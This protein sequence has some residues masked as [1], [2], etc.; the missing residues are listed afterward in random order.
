[1][2]SAV[3]AMSGWKRGYPQVLLR[4]PPVY[5]LVTWF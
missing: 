5:P 4:V 1:M 3:G 2:A